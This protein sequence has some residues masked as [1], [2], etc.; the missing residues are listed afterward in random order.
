M[1]IEMFAGL[2]LFIMSWFELKY[3]KIPSII[4]TIAILALAILNFQ[5]IM[6]GILGFILAW[7]LYEFNYI[8]KV[9]DIK[10]IVII[11]LMINNLYYF[12]NFMLLIAVFGLFYIGISCLILDK[13]KKDVAFVPLFFLIYIILMVF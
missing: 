9:G 6:F 4:P 12:Y 13:K 3:K 11:S 5:Y 10:A 7:L 8:E 1:I 2:F